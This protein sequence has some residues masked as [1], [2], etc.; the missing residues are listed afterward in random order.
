VAEARGSS[1][2]V[3]PKH[4]IFGVTDLRDELVLFGATQYLSLFPYFVEECRLAGH[5]LCASDFV[6]QTYRSVLAGDQPGRYQHESLSS[7]SRARM[8]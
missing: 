1:L 8:Q 4:G 7:E 5:I 6:A 3:G 2:P